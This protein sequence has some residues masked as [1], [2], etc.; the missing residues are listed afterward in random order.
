M[1]SF[2]DWCQYS[3]LYFSKTYI[4]D[5]LI[6]RNT[7]GVLFTVIGGIWLLIRL[8]SLNPVADLFLK[9]HVTTFCIVLIG[10][11]CTLID[12]RPDTKM[13]MKIHGLDIMISIRVGDVIAM[14]NSCV[15]PTNT[16]FETNLNNTISEESIQGQFT[17]QF[18]DESAYLDADIHEELHD[19]AYEDL[20]SG[21]IRPRKKRKYPI[22]TVVKVTPRGRTFY[23]LAMANINHKGNAV[24]D[25]EM[26]QHSLLGLWRFLREAGDYERELLIPLIGTGRGR[27]IQAREDIIC[28]IIDS[29]IE[30]STQG[31]LCDS[32]SIVIYSNDFYR[33][34]L[35]M[36]DLKNYLH[37]Q[38]RYSRIR[39]SLGSGIK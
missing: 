20:P 13:T 1:N 36:E 26:I 3:G 17:K 18:Y 28:E 19:I 32:L 39:R 21:K 24:C 27:V 37:A 38:C 23:L 33:Y 9:N 7:L 31:R 12:R 35:K 16:T 15:I 2:K 30:A 29:F 6:T 22:G 5:K 34:N 14:K 4:R 8:I 10:I 25:L 11:I